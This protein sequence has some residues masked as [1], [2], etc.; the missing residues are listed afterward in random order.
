[1]LA[2]VSDALCFAWSPGYLE[3]AI[4]VIVALLLFGTKL[5]GISRSLGRSIKEFKKGLKDVK[6]DIES[7]DDDAAKTDSSAKEDAPSGDKEEKKE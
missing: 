1:M 7:E 3:I 2:H 4:I 5:P 6:D